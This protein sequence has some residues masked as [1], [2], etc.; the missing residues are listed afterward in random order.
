VTFKIRFRG[1]ETHTRQQRLPQPSDDARTLRAAAWSLHEQGRWP[2]K[3]VR[4]VGLGISELGPPPPVQGD[5]FSGGPD[6][7]HDSAEDR[8]LN[9]TLD[10]INQRFGAGAVRRGGGLRHNF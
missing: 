9:A 6:R 1:F 7:G 10:R 3:P 2:D 4:L 8:R 5:L